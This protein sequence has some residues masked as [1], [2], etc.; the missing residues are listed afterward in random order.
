VNWKHSPALAGNA[1]TVRLA[2][3]VSFLATLSLLAILALARSAQ[4]LPI[5]E[6]DSP[7]PTLA[8]A[9]L[10]AEA[11]EDEEAED[12][13]WEE[14]FEAGDECEEAEDGEGEECEEEDGFETP[15]ECRLSSAEATVSALGSHDKVRL[16]VRY[17][18]TTPTAVVVDFGLHGSKGSLYM[19]ESHEHFSRRGVFRETR[20]LSDSEMAR[21]VGA[22]DFTVQL[23]AV[24]APRYCR[25]LLDRH[26]TVR[27]AVPGG[28]TWIDPEA[29]R[30]RARS[31]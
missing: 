25:H 16:V 10:S 22:R 24:H 6:P 18:A 21:T 3:L 2:W 20:R 11:D 15:S 19:G 26:L 17:T 31:R 8:A 13:S 27:H 29:S 14:D 23:Y 4:A 5:V 30:R 7:E 28:L 12:S 1:R 9:P